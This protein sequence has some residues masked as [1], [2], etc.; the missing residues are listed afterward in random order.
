MLAC[1]GFSWLKVKL[2]PYILVAEEIKK[3]GFY[4]LDFSSKKAVSSDEEKEESVHLFQL[5]DALRLGNA[6]GVNRLDQDR[7]SCLLHFYKNILNYFSF[8]CC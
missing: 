1:L 8:Y 3:N 7:L 2:L 5:E 6:G 4:C